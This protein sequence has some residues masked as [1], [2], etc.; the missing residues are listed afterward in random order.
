[1]SNDDQLQVTFSRKGLTLSVK[2]HG[3][4]SSAYLDLPLVYYKGYQIDDPSLT[5]VKSEEGL[6]RVQ[7]NGQ[8]EGTFTIAYAGTRLAQVT[9]W[10]SCLTTMGVLVYIYRNTKN[11][12]QR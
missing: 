4:S 10:V 7:L 3:A 2:Y 9:V 6:V 12:K 1:M 8:T 11:S 5:L